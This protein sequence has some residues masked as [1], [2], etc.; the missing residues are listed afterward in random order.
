MPPNVSVTRPS[1]HPEIAQ[2]IEEMRLELAGQC[3]G[4]AIDQLR[5]AMGMTEPGGEWQNV[6]AAMNAL[7]RTYR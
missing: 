4:W 2:A 7:R 3:P 1:A 6:I 5:H